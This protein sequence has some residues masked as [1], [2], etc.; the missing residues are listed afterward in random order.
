[1][2][3]NK[4]ILDVL[5]A[6]GDPQGTVQNFL[7]EH[8]VPNKVEVKWK[9]GRGLA[10]GDGH[11]YCYLILNSVVTLVSDASDIPMEEVRHNEI[12]PSIKNC[13]FSLFNMIINNYTAVH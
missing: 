13:F 3:T 4:N 9:R 8:A 5:K 11:P 6:V 7:P 2:G 12:S 1:M 10:D